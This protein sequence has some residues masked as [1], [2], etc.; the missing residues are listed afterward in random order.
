MREVGRWGMCRIK[1]G[2][3]GASVQLGG[4]L[5][6]RTEE[7]RH[8]LFGME[9]RCLCTKEPMDKVGALRRMAS[10]KLDVR[11]IDNLSMDGSR[12]L[13]WFY[14]VWYTSFLSPLS[15]PFPSHVSKRSTR[16]SAILLAA[17]PC[18]LALSPHSCSRIMLLLDGFPHS[19]QAYFV[20]S[21]VAAY[22]RRPEV[23]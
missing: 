17:I 2:K 16:L 11:S 12:A 20:F 1:G 10:V 8:R 3:H 22:Q 14:K 7:L 9:G 18:P 6:L 13:S 19:V 15:K 21:T 5:V 4:L 23:Y